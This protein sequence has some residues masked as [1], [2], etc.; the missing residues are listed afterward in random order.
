MNKTTNFKK[1]FKIKNNNNN[2]NSSSN[3]SNTKV[4]KITTITNLDIELVLNIKQS[5]LNFFG[6]NK[7]A[8]LSLF[9]LNNESN[10]S[11][12]QNELIKFLINNSYYVKNDEENIPVI[13][14]LFELKTSNSSINSLLYLNKA[15]KSKVFVEILIL[16]KFNFIYLSDIKDDK[17]NSYFSKHIVYNLV[18]YV[19]QKNFLFFIDSNLTLF[20]FIDFDEHIYNECKTIHKINNQKAFITINILNE[21]NNETI[22]TCKIDI[23]DKSDRYN[24]NKEDLVDNNNN[25]VK[26]L[27]CMN[28]KL[29]NLLNYDFN[30]VNYFY[31]DLEHFINCLISYINTTSNSNNN[32]SYNSNNERNNIVLNNNKVHSEGSNTNNNVN[33]NNDNYIIKLLKIVFNFLKDLK[34]NNKKTNIII[35]FPILNLNIIDYFK[36]IEIINLF[37]NLFYMSQVYII[38]RESCMFLSE[39]YNSISISKSIN[40]QYNNF[41]IKKLNNICSKESSNNQFNYSSKTLS[42]ELLFVYSLERTKNIKIMNE[43]EFSNINNYLSNN[44]KFRLGIF[45]DNNFEKVIIIEQQWSTGLIL[46]HNEFKLSV[47]PDS[48]ISVI[49]SNN[50]NNINTYMLPEVAHNKLKLIVDITNKNKCFLESAFLGAFLSRLIPKKSF[51]TCLRAGNELLKRLIELLRL[52]IP[53]PLEPNYFLI[54]VKKSNNNNNNDNSAITK[55][56]FFNYN[57]NIS[58]LNKQSNFMLDC[59]NIN[60]CKIKPYNPLTDNCLSSFFSSSVVRKYLKKQGFINKKGEVLKDPDK[61]KLYYNLKN[62]KL[63]DKYESKEKKVKRLED[64][65]N[66][67]QI[68]L[69]NLCSSN[70]KKLNDVPL[71]QLEKTTVLK[72]CNNNLKQVLPSIYNSTTNKFNAFLNNNNNNSLNSTIT[73]LKLKQHN[74]DLYYKEIKNSKYK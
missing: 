44:S 65:T 69:K 12:I 64:T 46:V 5:Q 68:Q 54:L 19:T 41:N 24:C 73:C 16:D 18:K 33:N 50:E 55:S 28:K 71:S 57:K 31:Y 61:N 4:K 7:D 11:K 59:V 38:D 72:N 32:N 42:R 17:N 2:N 60:N 74:N 23:F 15:N 47:F 70:I 62:K 8:L 58:D 48:L 45:I 39:I 20:D 13:F 40:Q 6:L 10:I 14:D 43:D 67:L 3:T 66:K 22:D 1:L 51:N 53:F 21:E 63:L 37:T 29:F 25:K 34:I 26:D 52:N 27:E 9:K 30:D 36:N 35:K 49:K 56:Y